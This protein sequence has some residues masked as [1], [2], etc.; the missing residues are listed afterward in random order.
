MAGGLGTGKSGSATAT[1]SGAA[2]ASSISIE[3]ADSGAIRLL[4][5]ANDSG[6]VINAYR[7][8]PVPERRRIVESTISQRG[9]DARLRNLRRALRP[10]LMGV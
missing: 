4:S 10:T 1:R 2:S 7:S 6:A 9:R 5:G 8:L 3:D